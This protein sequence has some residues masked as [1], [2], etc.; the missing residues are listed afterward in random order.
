M[1]TDLR[2][3]TEKM[4]YNELEAIGAKIEAFIIRAPRDWFHD[5]YGFRITRADGSTAVGH[6]PW[7]LNTYS[8]VLAIAKGE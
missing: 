1:T 6:V 3:G 2:T 8:A 5:I 7:D 4:F